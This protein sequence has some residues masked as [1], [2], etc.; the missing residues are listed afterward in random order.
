MFLYTYL[1][2]GIKNIWGHISKSNYKSLED[3]YNSTWISNTSVDTCDNL[4]AVPYLIFIKKF[5]KFIYLNCLL[6]TLQHV[7]II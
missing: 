2:T 3:I 7:K 1:S 6:L 4:D 5:L